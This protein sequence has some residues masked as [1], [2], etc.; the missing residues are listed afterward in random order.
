[1]P[2]AAAPTVAVQAVAE[3]PVT[4]ASEATDAV[5][6]TDAPLKEVVIEDT[7]NLDGERHNHGGIALGEAVQDD[8][9][10]ISNLD[11]EPDS[12]VVLLRNGHLEDDTAPREYTAADTDKRKGTTD[13][14]G[15]GKGTGTNKK[16]KKYNKERENPK[17][18]KRQH[19]KSKAQK[20]TSITGAVTG[21]VCFVVAAAAVL[22]SRRHAKP[23]PRESNKPWPPMSPEP[24]TLTRSRLSQA[25]ELDPLLQTSDFVAARCSPPRPA[26]PRSHYIEQI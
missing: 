23:V 8:D 7:I 6:V 4:D 3:S 21:V 2:P 10:P 11:V 12:T 20:L 19:L 9:Y 16:G 5:E 26:S 17:S 24:A 15:R 1:M 25:R 18:G 22:V 13:G 14:K